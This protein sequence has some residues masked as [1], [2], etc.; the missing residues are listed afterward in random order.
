MSAA[1]AGVASAAR[2][3][4]CGSAVRHGQG[5]VSPLTGPKHVT[6]R[7]WSSREH[8]AHKRLLVAQDTLADI[9]DTTG[10]DVGIVAEQLAALPGSPLRG[11]AGLTPSPARAASKSLP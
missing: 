3:W 2:L 9:P 4:G 8:R 1:P 10:S 6:L 7:G 5:T 11:A